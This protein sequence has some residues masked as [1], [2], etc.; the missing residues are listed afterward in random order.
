M[1]FY[2]GDPNYNDPYYNDLN[3]RMASRDS[4]LRDLYRQRDSAKDR[5]AL[6]ELHEIAAEIA[7]LEALPRI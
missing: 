2:P 7:R 1:S 5:G 6:K 3:R 4:V